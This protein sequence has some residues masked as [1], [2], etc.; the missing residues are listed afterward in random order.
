MVELDYD[1]T[2]AKDDILAWWKNPDRKPYYYLSGFG[3]TGKSSTTAAILEALDSNVL[4]C[5]PT[6]KAALVM[7][8]KTGIRARTLHSVLYKPGGMSGNRAQIEML[9]ELAELS[10]GH[11]SVPSIK[12]QLLN[13][14]REELKTLPPDSGRRQRLETA[15]R[16]NLSNAKDLASSN[17]I[18]NL[19]MDSVVKNHSLVVVD[20]ASMIPADVFTDLLSFNVPVL[21]QGD[22]GQLPPVKSTSP[23]LNEKPDFLL[24]KIHR[25]AAESPIIRLATL[26]REGKPLPL[27]YHG[28]CLVTYDSEEDRAMEAD[29][30]IVGTHKTRWATND[31]VRNLLGYSGE[32]PQKNEKVICRNNNHQLGLL[33]GDQFDVMYCL[34]RENNKC[35]IG[36][37]NPEMQISV[38]AHREY[39]QKKTPNPFTKDKAECFDYSYA[40][41]AHSSQG[42]EWE[43]VYVRDE[44]ESFP[45][46][47][48]QWLYT[49]ISRAAKKVTIRLSRPRSR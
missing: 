14:F 17:P 30:I 49:A 12:A 45:G 44:S 48:R 37:K 39:F 43:R 8:R 31:K 27:G 47:Q 20:E 15:I 36:V 26:A 29:Q 24:T 1:Q 46:Q 22:P 35:F 18:F 23:L 34:P 33:N 9:R 11:P 28:D 32:L 38:S 41:T 10:A 7:T 42:S 3:G 13:Q 40:I 21:V 16:T 6:G 25:Q 5:A 19:N 2:R 4:L